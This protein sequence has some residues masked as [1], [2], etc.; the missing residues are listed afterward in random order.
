MET[1]ELSELVARAETAWNRHEM[2]AFSDLFSADADFVNVAGWWWRGRDEIEAMHTRLHETIFSE[3]QI[4]MR[5]LGTRQIDDL[6]YVLH[7]GWTMVKQSAGGVRHASGPRDGIW[8]WIVRAGDR[9]EIVASHNSDTIA[10]P[11]DHPLAAITGN[12]VQD[13]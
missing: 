8:T 2:A 10:M 1:G 13:A 6:V 12:A 4:E 3:S 5:I 7:V 9:F 11:G